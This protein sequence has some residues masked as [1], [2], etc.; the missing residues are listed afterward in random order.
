MAMNEIVQSL[1][2]NPKC[3]RRRSNGEPKRLK[4]VLANGRTWMGGFFMGIINLLSVIIEQI[5]IIHFV[6]F[7]TK[8]NPLVGPHRNKF[9]LP[10]PWPIS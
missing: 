6:V 8:N 3:F 2:R 1:T 9:T 7:K 4:T 5:H 10:P